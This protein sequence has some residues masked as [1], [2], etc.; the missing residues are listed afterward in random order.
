MLKT[1]DK[2][3][4]PWHHGSILINF[5]LKV[6]QKAPKSKNSPSDPLAPLNQPSSI[7]P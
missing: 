6:C 4:N 2:L 7:S 1:A 3:E 5:K